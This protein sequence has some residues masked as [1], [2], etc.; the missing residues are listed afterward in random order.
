MKLGTYLAAAA[1]AVALVLAV[2]RC[3]VN[4]DLGVAPPIDAGSI[5]EAPG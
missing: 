3:G 1:L 2:A 4:V 5:D